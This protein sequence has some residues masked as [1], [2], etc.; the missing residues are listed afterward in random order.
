MCKPGAR[1][2]WA[3]E[4]GPRLCDGRSCLCQLNTH[5]RLR[6]S[7]SRPSFKRLRVFS[8]GLAVSAVFLVDSWLSCIE[9]LCGSEMIVNQARLWISTRGILIGDVRKSQQ[10]GGQ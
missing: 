9:R 10:T 2:P 1:S 4:S 5:V 6:E 3:R 7:H 8:N